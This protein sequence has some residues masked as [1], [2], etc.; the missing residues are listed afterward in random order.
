MVVCSGSWLLWPVDKTFSVC[1]SLTLCLS[2]YTHPDFLFVRSWLPSIFFS[3]G[4]TFGHL[5]RKLA[6]V[7]RNQQD[8]TVADVRLVWLVVG[9]SSSSVEASSCLPLDPDVH[10]LPG[11]W[12][13]FPSVSC[14]LT[15]TFPTCEILSIVPVLVP[16]SGLCL[17]QQQ[18][19]VGNTMQASF[20]GREVGPCMLRMYLFMCMT[21]F[22]YMSMGAVCIN[23]FNV[24]LLVCL[25]ALMVFS[26]SLQ[27][28]LVA[29]K[30][31][32]DWFWP[33]VEDSI[34]S[35]WR[36]A[37]VSHR[38]LI[39]P[40]V[41]LWSWFLRKCHDSLHFLPQWN[42]VQIPCCAGNRL[43]YLGRKPCKLVLPQLCCPTHL[44]AVAE[45]FCRQ[46][47]QPTL[48]V[49]LSLSS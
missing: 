36:N 27:V 26:C 25:L 32:R 31:K 43:L 29:T 11:S 6:Q 22:L 40:D 2:S 5:G 41:F 24:G 46:T 21:V 15:C 37:T 20:P 18:I 47:L 19:F 28:E 30:D 17:D 14:V 9:T 4:V 38:H 7:G 39:P 42:I 1:F 16:R 48:Y 34:S 35:R 8:M 33:H 12:C 23:R 3:G 49:W 44:E 10:I 13:P 45:W